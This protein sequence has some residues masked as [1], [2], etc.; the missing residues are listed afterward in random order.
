MTL[1]HILYTPHFYQD[2]K[3]VKKKHWDL[4]KIEQAVTALFN[5]DNQLLKSHYKDHQLQGNWSGFR[6][7]HLDSDWLLFYQI[8]A[9]AQTLVLAFTGSHD[10][11]KTR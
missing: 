11:L 9:K 4:N 7:L 10:M 2:V 5:Q 1:K 6:E 8:D 3:V